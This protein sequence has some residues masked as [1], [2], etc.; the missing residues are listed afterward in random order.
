LP[1]IGYYLFQTKNEAE[2]QP[3]DYNTLQQAVGNLNYLW[4]KANLSYTP[5]IYTYLKH[6][7][8]QMK[9]F[10]GIGDMLKDDVEHIHQKAAKI[11][12]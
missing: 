7:I 6:A 2:P 3:Q 9:R 4:S 1:D 11:E 5:K 10:N 8:N 12:T